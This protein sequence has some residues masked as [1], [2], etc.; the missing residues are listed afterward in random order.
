MLVIAVIIN[1]YNTTVRWIR[2]FWMLP[3][4]RKLCGR[5]KNRSEIKRWFL[6]ISTASFSYPLLHT[7]PASRRKTLLFCLFLILSR[8]RRASP[9]PPR[10]GYGNNNNNNDKNDNNNKSGSRNSNN[11]NKGNDNNSVAGFLRAFSS[12][13]YAH[14]FAIEILRGDGILS[15][16]LSATGLM[17]IA[18]SQFLFHSNPP[19]YFCID[20]T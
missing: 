18:A 16:S 11:N 15:P 6:L 17:A 9:L 3:L 5:G 13:R 7:L 10:N 1:R 20:S 2:T 19:T 14:S 12:K 8:S 4:L